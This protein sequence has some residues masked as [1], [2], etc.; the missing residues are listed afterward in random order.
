MQDVLCPGQIQKSEDVLH[1]LS[2]MEDQLLVGDLEAVVRTKLVAL[3]FHGSDGCVPLLQALPVRLEVKTCDCHFA[4]DN[5]VHCR[6][7]I[8]KNIEENMSFM[9]QC[10]RLLFDDISCLKKLVR[11]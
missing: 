7:S 4:G 10:R 8:W 5:R 6:S 3:V 1:P 2:R 9:Q 11:V